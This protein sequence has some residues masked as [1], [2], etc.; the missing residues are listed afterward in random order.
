[1]TGNRLA[2]PVGQMSSAGREV[3]S[4]GFEWRRP[5]FPPDDLNPLDRG[6]EPGRSV[7]RFIEAKA[8]GQRY[9]GSKMTRSI[10]RS[11]TVNEAKQTTEPAAPAV[12]VPVEYESAVRSLIACSTLD[13]AKYWSDKAD[14]LAAWARIYHHDRAGLEAKRLKL[15][16]YRRMGELAKEL[17]PGGALGKAPGGLALGRAPG[18]QSLLIEAGL[19]KLQ[20][21]SAARLR[22]LPLT[23][24]SALVNSPRP[25]SPSTVHACHRGSSAW[26]ELTRPGGSPMSFRTWTRGHDSKSLAKLLA[27]DEVDKARTLVTELIEWLDDFERHLPKRER[28]SSYHQDGA[29][30]ASSLPPQRGASE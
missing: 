24:F 16:A 2:A 13:D 28:L 20:A 12:N 21:R 23:K 30:N 10:V 29:M 6:E 8:D 26:F 17:R 14:A 19:S 15:H 18:P 5:T 4:T 11:F 1:V 25:P 7:G 27:P 9:E 3:Y 22:D